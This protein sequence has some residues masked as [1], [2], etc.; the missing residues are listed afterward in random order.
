MTS[1]DL[2]EALSLYRS[3]SGM[4][5]YVVDLALILFYRNELIFLLLQE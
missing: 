5:R 3:R 1:Y 2:F 4:K